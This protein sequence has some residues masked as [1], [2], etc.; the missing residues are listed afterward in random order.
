MVNSALFSSNSDEWATPADF[1]EALNNEFKFNLDV[2][3]VH[4]RRN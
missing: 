2:R 4:F 1:F 3:R